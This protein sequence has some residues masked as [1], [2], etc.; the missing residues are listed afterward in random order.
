MPEFSQ[1]TTS[2]FSPLF[3]ANIGVDIYFEG[4]EKD[5]YATNMVGLAATQQVNKNLRLK[6]MFSRFE[7][8]ESENYDIIG[9]YLFGERDFDRSKPTFGQIVNPIG[10]RYV[11]AVCPQSTEYR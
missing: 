4:R 9:A 5:R 8:D 1:L 10:S 7:N 2:V 3:S 11:P 6:W